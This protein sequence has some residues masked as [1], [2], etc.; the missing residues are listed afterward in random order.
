[1]LKKAAILMLIVF[2]TSPLTGQKKAKPDEPWLVI[3]DDKFDKTTTIM[4]NM[5]LLADGKKSEGLKGLSPWGRPV[6]TFVIIHH[7]NDPSN[8]TVALGFVA[9]RRRWEYRECYDVVCLIDN[10]RIEFP[11]SKHDGQV[12]SDVVVEN[13]KIEPLPYADLQRLWNGKTIELK[14]CNTEFALSPIEMRMLQELKGF[15]VPKIQ[16]GEE[17]IQQISVPNI[18][19]DP[20]GLKAEVKGNNFRGLLWGAHKADVKK[21]EGDVKFIETISNGGL[22]VI[23]LQGKADNLKCTIGFFFTEDKL[24]QGR[25]VFSEEH[26]YKNQYIDDFKSVKKSLTEKY[27]KPQKDGTLWKDDLYKDDPTEWGMAVATGRLA[28]QAIWILD[29]TEIVLQLRGDNFNFT[30]IL[31]YK[32]TIEEHQA[33]MK[34][35]EEKAKSGIW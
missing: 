12:E 4:P 15:L 24:V 6:L 5:K 11:E 9:L 3:K 16:K 19:V 10:E 23:G 32:S 2:S 27:G 22:E 7:E 18:K 1:M 8:P 17:E 35:A 20:E 21:A 25:Y 14:I 26:V 33:L 13:I 29:E 28:Y 30:H 34:K 31:Q